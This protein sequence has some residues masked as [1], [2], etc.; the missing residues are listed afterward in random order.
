M[1]RHSFP[2]A[3]AFS[4]AFLACDRQS[5]EILEPDR[6]FQKDFPSARS[7]NARLG[8]GV[9][10]GNALDA[11]KEGDWGVTLKSDYF[12]RIADSGFASVRIP[13]K[14]SGHALA[15]SPYTIDTAFMNR[16]A[17]AVDEALK[18]KLLVVLDMHHYDSLMAKPVAELPRF[19]SMWKQ[20][21]E[22]FR[23]YPPELIFELLN[24]PRDRMDAATWNGILSI[25][26]DSL[27]AAQPGRALVVGTSPWGGVSGLG[28]LSLPDDGNLIV[29]VHYYDPHPFTHQGATFETGANDWLGTTWRATPAQRASVDN[30]IAFIRDW[31]KDHDRPIYMG[32]FGS[33]IRADSVS[34]A[35][36]TEY[37]SRKFDTAGFSSAL[38]NYSSDFGIVDDATDAWRTYMSD[39]LL[40]H[41]RN[42]KLDSILAATKPIELGTYVTF[43]DFE[44]S[45]PHLTASGRR[46]R[47]SQGKP[48][49]AGGA[50]WYAYTSDSSTFASGD[51]TRIRNYKEVDSGKAPNFNLLIG[52]WGSQGQG[53]HAKMHLRGGNYPYAGLGAGI[54][55]GWDSTFADLSKLTAIQFR[56]KGY[57]EWVMQAISDSVNSDTVENWG[58]MSYSFRPKAD[59]ETYIVPAEV[60]APLRYSRQEKMKLTWEDV[61]KKIIALEFLQGQSYGQVVDT[62]LEIW[63]DDIRLIGETNGDLGM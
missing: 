14:F 47:E 16:V 52:P 42:P 3:I 56:A 55:G 43:D 35:L 33:I 46:W 21:A 45:L 44:D 5:R 1:L 28:S 26:I 30:D 34:R 51:G 31:A 58:H 22:R 27:R 36:Y 11:P 63:V 60:L 15:A 53:L 59:W 6:G 7:L 2:V 25:A 61:R 10:V 8:V 9:N 13:A 37:L 40:H 39:A 20:I 41:G 38:W 23:D 57:G 24:E 19:L 54:L 32:E 29:A 17:W 62:T 12:R 48:L 50:N 49:T 18:N 4:L